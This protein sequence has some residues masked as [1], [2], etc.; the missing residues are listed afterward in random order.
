MSFRSD[1]PDSGSDDLLAER[2]HSQKHHLEVL[3]TERDTDD[4]DAADEAEESMEGCDFDSSYEDP[5]H[6]HQYRKTAAVIGIGLY[7]AAER[8]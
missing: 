5:E 6:V 1:F 4:R 3:D 7:L 8:P 2:N